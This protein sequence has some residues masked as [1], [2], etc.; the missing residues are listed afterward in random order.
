MVDIAELVQLS[1]LSD[2]DGPEREMGWSY[3]L[4]STALI[5]RGNFDIIHRIMLYVTRG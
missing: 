5:R 1:I 3:A 4:F 2:V